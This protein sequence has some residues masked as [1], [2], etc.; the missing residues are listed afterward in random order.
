VLADPRARKRERRTDLA[1]KQAFYRLADEK[2]ETILVA[3]SK[4]E[5]RVAFSRD[6]L[7]ATH[8]ADHPMPNLLDRLAAPDC[9]RLGSNWDRCGVH[10]VEPIE[11]G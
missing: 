10:Y 5:W 7:I 6:D 9:P 8:G 1:V 2:R 4:C 3:C 11:G